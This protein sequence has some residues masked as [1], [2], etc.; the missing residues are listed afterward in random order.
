MAFEVFGLGFWGLG[1]KA[2]NYGPLVALVR[3]LRP[4][5]VHTCH[6]PA[7]P[8]QGA[9]LRTQAKQQRLELGFFKIQIE[10]GW[11]LRDDETFLG[12]RWEE[13]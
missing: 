7:T 9:V 6:V 4:G 10:G 12:V 5:S 1:L 11:R 8:N 3:A 13:F 2:L